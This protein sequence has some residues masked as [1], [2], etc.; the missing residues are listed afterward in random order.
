MQL[1]VEKCQFLLKDGRVIQTG[2]ISWFNE[3]YR[4]SRMQDI[5]IFWLDLE[6]LL[7]L[8]KEVIEDERY[9]GEE[10]RSCTPNKVKNRLHLQAMSLGK[11]K[12]ERF[13]HML[14]VWGEPPAHLRIEMRMPASQYFGNPMVE[15]SPG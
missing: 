13:S 10:S 11:A 6:E 7:L 8:E 4:A 15:N 2:D 3:P 5:C 1:K 12:N 14:K 9:L